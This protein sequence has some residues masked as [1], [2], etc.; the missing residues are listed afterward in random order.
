MR[1]NQ[2][3]QAP[4][5]GELE[6]FDTPPLQER[7]AIENAR[8]EN[9]NWRDFD[10]ARV[11]FWSCELKN[12]VFASG[13]GEKWQLTDVH[14]E[15]C[16]FSNFVGLELDARRCEFFDGKMIGFAANDA[17]FADVIFRNCAL[18][19]AQFRFGRFERVRFEGCVLRGADFGGS[20]L[21]KVVFADCDLRE[22]DFSGAKLRGA[23][24]RTCQLEGAKIS[25]EAAQGLIIEPTQAAFL[26]AGLG[27]DVRWNG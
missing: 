26:A 13:E 11:E 10:V 16:D 27:L 9:A 3:L 17:R 14:L 12:C 22:C 1:K 2:T 24:V 21:Q 23:D 5:I 18:L 15:N 7:A 25:L 19:H 6:T 8:V 20:D 4:R